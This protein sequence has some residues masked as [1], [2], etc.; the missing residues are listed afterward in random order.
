VLH[1]NDQRDAQEKKR[2]E[3]DEFIARLERARN[4]KEVPAS[5]T[6]QDN[7]NALSVAKQLIGSSKRELSAAKQ[8]VGQAKREFHARLQWSTMI[9]EFCSSL[10][11]P[12]S[13]DEILEK[14][15][16]AEADAILSSFPSATSEE[17]TVRWELL[18][19]IGRL[20]AEGKRG[21]WAR[22]DVDAHKKKREES[23]IDAQKMKR[24]GATD[25]EI[26]YVG[27]DD[28]WRDFHS[29][30]MGEKELERRDEEIKASGTEQD[31]NDALSVAEQ[32]MGAD[33]R[34]ER[35]CEQLMEADKRLEREEFTARLERN[36]NA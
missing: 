18:E 16:L 17:A 19:A 26:A 24:E 15:G 28:Y 34:L 20:S 27:S 36:W 25:E 5:G 29:G 33:K 21:F 23:S 3:R 10:G 9:E 4:G 30:E 12:V 6:E 13:P 2:L 35:D 7:N 32:L 11:V 31:N 22:V 14:R 1:E 8:L